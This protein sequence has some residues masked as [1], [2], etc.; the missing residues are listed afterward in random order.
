MTPT[1]DCRR[2]KR[3]ATP[4]SWSSGKGCAVPCCF[5]TWN[6]LCCLLRCCCGEKRWAPDAGYC[7]S[8]IAGRSCQP[9]SHSSAGTVDV[10][11]H[12]TCPC[13]FAHR[14]CPPSQP[15]F[16]RLQGGGAATASPAC[17]PV[18][19][20]LPYAEAAKLVH[21]RY[22]LHAFGL[23]VAEVV[24][25]VVLCLQGGGAAAGSGCPGRAPQ[26]AHLPQHGGAP[27]GG[28]RQPVC[29]AAAPGKDPHGW[30]MQQC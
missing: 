5:Q 8:L 12:P 30:R 22:S 15:S 6:F 24:S 28:Q 26:R 4:T 23:L 14:C 7:A 20:T 2:G 1:S 18:L 9:L 29:V 21:A 17:L 27:Q 10:P 16:A 3:C 13:S 19:L 11:A 25:M